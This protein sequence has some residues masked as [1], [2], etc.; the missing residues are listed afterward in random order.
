[1]GD[2]KRGDGNSLGAKTSQPPK[3]SPG[4]VKGVEN[5][6][7]LGPNEERYTESE[8]EEVGSEP[9]NKEGEQTPVSS[10]AERRSGGGTNSREKS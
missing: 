6:L 4:H 1:V 9:I 7:I 5:P 3:W 10:D 8:R 2:E